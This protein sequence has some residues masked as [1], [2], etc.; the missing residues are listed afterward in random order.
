MKKFISVLLMML[1][2][3]C[4]II[5]VT[6][7]TYFIGENEYEVVRIIYKDGTIASTL[8]NVWCGCPTSNNIQSYCRD[9]YHDKGLCI[10]W[11]REYCYTCGNYRDIECHGVGG[12]SSYATLPPWPG[13]PD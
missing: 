9:H 11:V 8:A 12:C 4:C 6:A 3:A 10:V 13:F 7:S 2:V 1:L 5:P